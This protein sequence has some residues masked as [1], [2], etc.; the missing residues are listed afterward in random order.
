M[1]SLLYISI[2]YYMQKGGEGV[3]K[4]CKI[5]YVINGRP[6][7]TLLTGLVKIPFNS[8]S[9]FLSSIPCTFSVGR[10]APVYPTLQG[11]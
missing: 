1:S 3:Q 10:T 8:R 6:L 7:T 4:A 5:A 11:P 2:A 9:S